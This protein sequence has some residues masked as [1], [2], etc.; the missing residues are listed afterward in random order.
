[1]AKK[2]N[3]DEAKAAESDKE[4][5][6]IE[7]ETAS[8]E[9]PKTAKTVKSVVKET[10]EVDESVVT[11]EE[12]ATNKRTTKAGKHSAKSQKEEEVKEAKEARKATKTEDE[13]KTPKVHQK[14]TRSKLE[15]RGKNYR[16]VAELVDR[17]KTY[18]LNEALE[19]A[20]QTNPV[21]FDATVELHVRLAVDPKQADQNVRGTVVLPAG[22]GKTVR[23]A[24]FA[25]P[26]AAAKAKAAG[27]DIAGSDDLLA[28]LDKEKIEFDVLIAQ[29][30]MMPRLGKYARLLGPRG[31]MPNPKS[32]TVTTDVEKAVKEAKAGRVEYRVDST[33]IIHVG[34]GKISFGVDKLTDN[35]RALLAS[36]KGNK[37]ASVKG[38]FVL[39]AFVT[40]T[41][42]PSI[43]LST[44]DF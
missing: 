31:L 3:K 2:P 1:M 35:A 29:P 28:K 25:E 34:V 10:A 5:K 17:T 8:G 16:K 18:N 42:G 14:P 24:V 9:K 26:D 39:R 15:R 40:T 36:V 23:V 37:P 12:Q 6:A 22:T 44:S 38:A 32:G 7:T 11:D 19:L 27:A 21:K 13:D 20:T 30:N 43:P 41:M 33:G 4:I